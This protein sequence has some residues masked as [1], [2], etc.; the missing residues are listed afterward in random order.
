MK[1]KTLLKMALI[2]SLIG[3]VALFLISS[4]IKIGETEISKIS[5]SGDYVLVKGLVTQVTKTKESTIIQLQQENKIDVFLFTDS[6]IDVAEGNFIEVKGKI[7]E[8]EG[9]NE[10]IADEIRLLG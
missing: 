7:Q 2:C 9:K 4:T 10:I 1:E 3:L 8:Y 5:G 6:L